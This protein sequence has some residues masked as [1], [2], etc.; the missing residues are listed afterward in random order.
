MTKVKNKIDDC[1]ETYLLRC[2]NLWQLIGNTPMLEIQY[3]FRGVPGRIFAKSEYYNHTGSVHD[4]MVLNILY[5][6]CREGKIGSEKSLL[7]PVL[8]TSGISFAAIGRALGHEV[9]ILAPDWLDERLIARIKENG[10]KIQ[11]VSMAEGGFTGCIALSERMGRASNNYFLP[12]QFENPHN[13]EAHTRTT[14]KEIWKQLCERDLAPDAFVCSAVTGGTVTGVGRYLKAMKPVTKIHPVEII[15]DPIRRGENRDRREFIS[16]L[17]RSKV[18][19]DEVDYSVLAN[20]TDALMM[21]Q[22]LSF[23]LGLP[24]DISSGANMVGAIKVAALMGKDPVVVTLLSGKYS[25]Y[26]APANDKFKKML[27]STSTVFTGYQAISRLNDSF[28]P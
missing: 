8:D 4:R 12:R 1:P 27:I 7:I 20:E 28:C 19:L 17:Y 3:R 11:L 24:V 22:K 23:E 15:E 5:Q 25:H 6:A 14:G 18:K 2:L 26:S 21:T 10:A 16:T 13:S 9:I